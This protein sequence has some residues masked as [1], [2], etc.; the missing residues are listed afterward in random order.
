MLG[1]TGKGGSVADQYCRSPLF[2]ALEKRTIENAE[3]WFRDYRV[4][5][6]TRRVTAEYKMRFEGGKKCLLLAAS[7]YAKQ[8][9]STLISP[10]R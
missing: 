3:S 2:R 7:G 6:K 5:A 1:T 9:L 8:S 10:L 4:L